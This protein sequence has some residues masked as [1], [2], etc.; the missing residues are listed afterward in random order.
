[1]RVP[2]SQVPVGQ[3]FR[4]NGNLCYK[5]STRTASIVFSN[6]ALPFAGPT[7]GMW[8]YFGKDDVCVI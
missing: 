7:D 3:V 5:K 8:F 6:D 2:F 4:C 1:M